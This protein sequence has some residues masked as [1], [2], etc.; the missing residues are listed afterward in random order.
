MVT[1]IAGDEY[2]D[3]ARENEV[4][5][6]EGK[7]YEVEFENVRKSF[8]VKLIKTDKKTEKPVAN[9]KYEL[10]HGDELI[11]TLITGAD[12]TVE[13]LYSYVCHAD[14][15]KEWTVQEI[16]APDGYLLDETVYTL[17]ADGSKILES[18]ATIE[19][20]IE[21]EATQI[22]VKKF[23][24]NGKPMVG[25]VLQIFDKD[26]KAVTDPWI[27]TEDG[28]II[29]GLKIGE[30]YYLREIKK[31]DNYQQ[32]EDVAFVVQDTAEV[33]TVIMRNVPIFGTVELFKFDAE[34]PE[35]KLTGAK[36][37]IYIDRDKNGKY[38]K[39]VDVLYV[40]YTDVNED[41]KFTAG[42]DEDYEPFPM[43]ED[44]EGHYI[45][46]NLPYGQYLL[47]EIVAPD[48]FALDKDYYAFSITENG[49]TVEVSNT[50][51]GEGFLNAPTKIYIQKVDG[52]GQFLAGVKLQIE[53][54]EGNVVA[55]PWISEEK[56]YEITGL[57][58]VGKTYRL[59]ELETIDDYE[60]AEAVS[61]TIKDTAEVQ[62]VVMVNLKTPKTGDNEQIFLWMV[63]A[64]IGLAGVA[65]IS[66]QLGKTK[67]RK[68]SK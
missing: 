2:V 23:D 12:G 28:K 22:L 21:E 41:G 9:A 16:E 4:T 65:V 38:T 11:E 37:A 51:V 30:T 59:V 44:E 40:T 27:N 47:K 29:D 57:L 61:F 19:L 46:E 18:K 20:E 52:N 6:L 48:G 67:K 54:Q 1:E 8:N 53:D 24:E 56:A 3:E 13:S 66:A 45:C 31:P 33:Q 50:D 58:V 49:K 26:G 55:G 39:G 17:E 68:A 10:R 25:I 43:Y 15:D 60:L 5:I 32:A 62:N 34:Y 63:F 36:F 42:V 35:N 14:C 64:A 7:V